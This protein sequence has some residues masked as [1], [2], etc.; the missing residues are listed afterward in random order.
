MV[1]AGFGLI[2]GV[3]VNY[4][5]IPVGNAFSL[6]TGVALIAIAI[7][8]SATAYRRMAVREQKVSAKGIVLSLLAGVLF[9]FFYRF[10]AA[11][12]FTDFSL[13]EAGKIGPYSA[14][15]CFAAGVLLSNFIFNTVLMK[16]P[17]QGAP[18]S[19]AEYFKGNGKDHI[20][21]ILGGM[22]WGAG[23]IL[24]ILSAGKAG[25][26]ISFGLGQGNAMIAAIWGVLVWKEFRNAPA[27]TPRLLYGMF[28]CYIA[29]LAC[30]VYAKS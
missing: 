22:I 17:V 8:L 6:F 27:G 7:L 18:L 3:L 19:Y 29:G 2:L 28:F 12:M 9:G 11:A 20:M 26:A 21:G 13:P 25:F 24:S 4:V 15:V 23:L 30:I 10:I 5:A 14:T 1:G 16:R